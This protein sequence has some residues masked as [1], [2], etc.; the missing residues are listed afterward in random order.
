MCWCIF[1]GLFQ[2]INGRQGYGLTS[3]QPYWLR[4]KWYL[5]VV[6]TDM[7]LTIDSIASIHN[8]NKQYVYATY[9][10]SEMPKDLVRQIFLMACGIELI[11]QLL[12]T[13]KIHSQCTFTRSTWGAWRIITKSTMYIHLIFDA[14]SDSQNFRSC[15]VLRCRVWTN[16]WI[17][18]LKKTSR[19]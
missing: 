11:L 18:F 17:R 6:H 5:Y 7:G 14:A 3:N 12:H 4:V 9:S 10:N 2:C 19:N 13:C 15:V 16:S 8:I 1:I